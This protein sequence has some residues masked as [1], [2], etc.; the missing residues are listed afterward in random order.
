MSDLSKCSVIHWRGWK[1]GILLPGVPPPPSPLSKPTRLRHMIPWQISSN[2]Q[3][4][5]K[6]APV[7]SKGD[8][9]K[10]VK[11]LPLALPAGWREITLPIW[12]VT[13]SQLQASPVSNL[14]PLYPVPGSS[15]SNRIYKTRQPLQ[16]KKD[17]SQHGR[18]GETQAQR[19]GQTCPGLHS[20]EGQAGP[21]PRPSSRPPGTTLSPWHSNLQGSYKIL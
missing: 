21:E 19:G 8:T 12:D 13:I 10:G 16:Q 15:A 7:T 2:L 17:K 14:L 4:K 11:D 3:F 1:L 5:E 9:T 20:K 6:S 18:D